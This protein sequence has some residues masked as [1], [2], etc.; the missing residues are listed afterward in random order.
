MSRFFTILLVALTFSLVVWSHPV[1]ADQSLVARNAGVADQVVVILN[2]LKDE[3]K[4]E[5]ESLKNHHNAHA[6]MSADIK[7]IKSSIRKARAEIAALGK[8]LFQS[9]TSAESNRIKRVVKE[10][11]DEVIKV[12]SGSGV[13]SR[14]TGRELRQEPEEPK[15]LEEAIELLYEVGRFWAEA[16]DDFLMILEDEDPEII[17]SAI[18]EL[19]SSWIHLTVTSQNP[20]PHR[21]ATDPAV[22]VICASNLGSRVLSYSNILNQSV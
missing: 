4:P 15:N 10:L 17:L 3:L 5:V 6:D 22:T 14:G 12:G 18:E 19:P 9:L 20:R 16:L 2:N 11:V 7:H 8:A 1:R 13:A 21:G